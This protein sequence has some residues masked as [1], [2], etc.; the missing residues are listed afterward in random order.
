MNKKVL[1]GAAFISLL[2][3][4]LAG[5]GSNPSAGNKSDETSM[6]APSG[7]TSS[8]VPSGEK[9]TVKVAESDYYT[10]KVTYA[11]QADKTQLVTVEIDITGENKGFLSFECN[12]VNINLSEDSTEAKALGTFIMPNTD[13]TIGVQ[14]SDY[15]YISVRK[16]YDTYG[17]VLA[18][19]FSKELA[20]KHLG[21]KKY[22]KEFSVNIEDYVDLVM[23]P[24]Y[25]SAFSLYIGDNLAEGKCVLRQE[26]EKADI[27]VDFVMPSNNC[28]VCI[29]NYAE[30]AETGGYS[31]TFH[32][33]ENVKILG[34]EKDKKYNRLVFNLWKAETVNVTAIKIKKVG[35]EGYEDVYQAL[36]CYQ[37]L[38]SYSGS[39]LL[40]GDIEIQVDYEVTGYRNITFDNLSD[41][42]SVVSK[43]GAAIG[44]K[45]NIKFTKRE[46]VD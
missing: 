19:K 21:G 20:G 29:V 25:F 15:Y 27:T 6:S 9:H 46:D 13:V 4:G 23:N 5:C 34:P 39:S 28:D 45:V 17:T 33:D 2:V 24:D 32:N 26:A 7:Y 40:T 31:V 14:V 42:L 22:S 11:E 38:F 12:Q 18:D 35:E 1:I 3:S 8:D 37:K 44:E 10:S 36:D 30:P 43:K 16:F 41:V